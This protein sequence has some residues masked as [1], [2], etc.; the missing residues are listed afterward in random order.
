MPEEPT[1]IDGWLRTGPVTQQP[2]RGRMAMNMFHPSRLPGTGFPGYPKYPTLILEPLGKAG[3]KGPFATR[4][5][6]FGD[7]SFTMGSCFKVQAGQYALL[8]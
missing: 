4:M 5:M 7:S 8:S 1:S 3:A 2:F 6:C